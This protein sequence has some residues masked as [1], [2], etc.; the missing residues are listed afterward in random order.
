M[1][2][3]FRKVES[4]RKE[5][6]FD[7]YLSYKLNRNPFPNRPGIILNSPDD[8]QN[9][10][11]YID[12]L[13]S[14]EFD[15]F[16]SILIP[17]PDN[18][19]TK[20]I[21]FLMDYASKQGRGIG[22]TSF[23][24]AERNRINADWGDRQ[25]KSQEILLSVYV[26]P[27]P[28][29]QRKFWQ[30]CRLII[31]SM[32]EQNLIAHAFCRLRYFYGKLPE[33]ILTKI[34]QE[35]IFETL[36]S[37]EWINNNWPNDVAKIS[38]YE[39]NNAIKFQLE[40]EGISSDLINRVI[41]CGI[42]DDLFTK[43]YYNNISENDWKK[44]AANLLFENF[45]KVFKVA[46]FT[47]GIILFDELEKVVQYQN[48]QERRT[49]CDELRYWLIDGNNAN[50]KSEFYSILFVIHPYL[51][52]ILNPYWSA[53]GLERFAT[54]GGT[55]AENFTIFFKP[56]TNEQAIPLAIAYMKA[57]RITADPP[58]SDI[59][60]FTE[61]GLISAHKKNDGIPGKYLTFLYSAIEKAI[62]NNWPE[63]GTNEIEQVSTIKFKEEDVAIE[64]TKL[65]ET[66]TKLSD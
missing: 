56:L 39:S 41:N 28:G 61:E 34:D 52:E 36:G 66:K 33:A 10:T 63:I 50:T 64:T 54:L 51:Q 1:S 45:L 65:Q 11:I 43:Y 17:N 37:W 60:P 8:R 6:N 20:A 44:I 2:N 62:E 31:K 47:K 29:E 53:S 5:K 22:K 9:G 12:S 32:I 25:S 55:N 48:V 46:G 4:E 24:I 21:A 27:Q 13:R 18:G 49:F 30:I 3:L 7:R 14:Q 35:K 15:R 26:S 38:E 58:A 57:S 16:N 42:S 19:E 23:L 40:G 59:F